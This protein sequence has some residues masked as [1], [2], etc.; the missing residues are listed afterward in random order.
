MRRAQ[1]RITPE[2]LREWLP[3]PA[4]AVILGSAECAGEISII[5]EDPG[6]P[7][8]PEGALPTVAPTFRT[9]VPVEF[10]DW[11]AR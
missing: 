7:D 10:V 3:L 6:L 2:L 9:N 11:G 8:A 5:V 1:I 4:T